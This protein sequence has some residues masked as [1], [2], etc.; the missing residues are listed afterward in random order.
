MTQLDS[1]DHATQI[2]TAK[3]TDFK[4]LTRIMDEA[5]EY[6]RARSGE[7]A[8][9]LKE[10]ALSELHEHVKAGNCFVMKVD[11]KIVATM[12]I[13]DSDTFWG[14]PGTDGTALYVHKL[15]KHPGTHV[16]NVGLQ[17][18]SFAAH[19]AVQQHKEF[20]RCDTIATQKRLIDYY[21]R[22]SFVIKK[23][24][25]YLPSTRPGIFMEVFVQDLLEQIDARM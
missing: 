10:L 9:K 18:L 20:L 22:L 23:H 4:E 21:I 12:T 8:W 3:T 13:T 17:F 1:Q 5:N 2:I 14:K 16:R 7:P 11:Q 24:F 25:V 15:M 19:K 6:S